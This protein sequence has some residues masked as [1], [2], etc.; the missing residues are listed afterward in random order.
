MNS[1]WAPRR[2]DLLADRAAATP[3]RTGLV[4]TT[5]GTEWSY[6]ELDHAVDR[7]AA[8]LAALGVSAGDSVGLLV[9]NRVAFLRILYATFRLG[10]RAIPFNL[11]LDDQTLGRQ[12]DRADPEL[13]VC[14]ATTA[15]VAQEGDDERTIVCVDADAGP[16]TL[17]TV[18]SDTFEPATTTAE[19]DRLLLFTSGTTG[20]PKGVRLTAKNLRASA[21]A[22]AF[23]LGVDPD[24]RWLAPLPA[25]HMG[26]LAPHLRSTLYGT[27]AVLQSGFEADRTLDALSRFDATCISLVPTAVDRL[28]DAGELPELRFVLCGGAPTSQALVERCARRDVPLCPTYGMTE[29]ASQAATALPEEARHHEGTV[30]QPLQWTDVTIIDADGSP[31]EAGG[32]GEIVVDGPTVTPGYDDPAA[33]DAALHASG[34]RTGDLGYR[35]EDGRLWVVGRVDDVII[36]GGENV[37]P[38]RVGAA[39]ES[40]SQIDDAA[41]VGLDDPEWGQRVGALVVPSGDASASA[42]I[43]SLRDGGL[44]QQLDERLAAYE[45]PKTI[46]VADALPRTASGT[47][48]REA[49][50]QRLREQG[51]SLD[52]S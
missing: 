23:R 44:R 35:D 22:S 19:T 37:H 24:D 14:S 36:T 38:E 25:Y 20:E 3:D 26:G 10:A 1:G 8:Q 48:D 47:V 51:V 17:D 16:P 45:R 33:T 50:R 12:I 30:G 9:G 5:D 13:L 11:D 32:R 6:R 41:V 49:V 39:I 52:E 21:V 18:D 31:V 46:A 40:L 27:T 28:L 34:F 7:T 42:L 4:R 29:T 2:S 15:G 43:G